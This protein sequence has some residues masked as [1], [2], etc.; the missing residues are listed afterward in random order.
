ML[1]AWNCLLIWE[2]QPSGSVATSELVQGSQQWKTYVKTLPFSLL[3]AL[4]CAA[5]RLRVSAPRAPV[6]LPEWLTARLLSTL[7]P[8]APPGPIRTGAGVGTATTDA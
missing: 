2:S 7:P 3:G 5:P 4:R 8:L 1:P 6:L